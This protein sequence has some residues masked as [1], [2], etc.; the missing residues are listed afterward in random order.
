MSL[1]KKFANACRAYNGTEDKRAK[2]DWE[3][4][5]KDWDEH[6]CWHCSYLRWRYTGEY[7]SDKEY[8]CA[9]PN[10]LDRKLGYSEKNLNNGHLCCDHFSKKK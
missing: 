10:Q 3:D 7:I 4:F 8:I 2:K 1:F 9:A 6:N 5:N